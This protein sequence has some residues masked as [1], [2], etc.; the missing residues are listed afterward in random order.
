MNRFLYIF[1]GVILIVVLTALLWAAKTHEETVASLPDILARD[2]YPLLTERSVTDI[3]LGAIEERAREI[4][5]RYPYIDDI[6]VRKLTPDDRT[7]TLYPYSYDLDYPDFPVQ[8]DTSYLRKA[9]LDESGNAIGVLYFRINAQRSRLFNAA[10]AGSIAA[11]LL[12][13]IL[14]LYTIRTQEKEVIKTTSLLE[15]KHRELI[16]LERLALVGQVTANL[17]HD[18]KKPVLNIRAE[19]DFLPE[20]ESKKIIQ[21]E[22]ELF[23]GMLRELQLE[24]F[25]RRDMERAEFLD[26]EEML[27]RSLRL[28]RYAQENVQVE[29]NL[30]EHLP[31]ILGQR[32]QFIQIFSNLFLNAFQA[33]DG[34]GVVQISAGT[35][36]ENGEAW[37]EIGVTDNGPGMPYEVLS[38]AFEPFYSTRKSSESTGLGLYITKTIIESMGGTIH[39]HSIPR[40]GTTF[41]IHFPVSQE[42]M[43]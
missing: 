10:I 21:D 31:F 39:V 37:L 3:N 4:Q 23:L 7:I 8:W 20:G 32:H 14:G 17:L 13:I 15:E 40:H 2:F 25:L 33:L 29:M 35:I 38:H 36:D 22:I 43:E 11:L 30:P 1:F 27:Q 28:V 16:H 5:L 6:I 24:G 19:T 9:L 18:L 34:E 42:E 26:V 12:V 41:T